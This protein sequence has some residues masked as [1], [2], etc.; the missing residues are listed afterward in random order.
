MILPLFALAN[1]GV[2][3]SPE[4]LAGAVRSP[5]TWGIILGARRRQV[6]RRVRVGGNLHD[7]P[8]LGEFGPGLTLD[9][10]AGGA[11]LSGIGFTISLFIIDLAISDRCAE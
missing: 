8:R 5:L 3:L 4:I 1:A 6:H 7:A 10:I 9:R 2:E 11:A